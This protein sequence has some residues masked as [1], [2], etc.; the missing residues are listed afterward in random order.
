MSS[1]SLLSSSPA[2]DHAIA[3]CVVTTLSSISAI[4]DAEHTL[5]T[6]DIVTP[7]AADL[8]G[9]TIHEANDALEKEFLPIFQAFF[10]AR[11]TFNGKRLRQGIALSK[12]ELHFGARIEAFL[13]LTQRLSGSAKLEAAVANTSLVKA[14]AAYL[15]S[16][17]T[18]V[19]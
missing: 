4:E 12:R 9:S 14:V 16:N 11:A 13:D 2:D 19:P 18:I 1:S 6:A 7:G 3:E 8:I 15:Q 17:F 5:A 10:L